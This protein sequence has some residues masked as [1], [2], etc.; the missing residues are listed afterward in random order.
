MT[1]KSSTRVTAALLVLAFFLGADY[2]AWAWATTR[3]DRGLG[4]LQ[5]RIAA[6]GWRFDDPHRTSA[7]WPFAARLVLRNA[8]L[9]SADGTVSWSAGRVGI[10][11]SIFRP[12]VITIV[13]DG[14]QTL[15]LPGL[16]PAVIDAQILGLSVSS[17]HPD[18]ATAIARS[19]AVHTALG[20]IDVDRAGLTLTWGA[21]Q[22]HLTLDL[23]GAQLP[24]GAGWPLGRAIGSLTLGL[25]ASPAWP[26]GS[27]SASAASW[28]DAGGRIA[29]DRAALDWGALNAT[30]K[31]TAR[32]D[33]NLQPAVHL[34]V[35]IAGAESAVAAL[36][37]SG[38]LSPGTALAAGAIL[39][40]IAAPQ[41]GSDGALSLPL[42]LKA[43][44][45][46]LA[47]IPIGTVPAIAWPR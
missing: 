20:T 43:G 38:V 21:G 23:A 31:G 32:L 25:T 18:A 26:G 45:L 27:Q 7:G 41:P 17:S 12:G 10:G 42:S 29:I 14:S 5:A 36:A 33:P 47:H 2:A 11:V 40:V 39:A 35:R 3:L 19:L 9:A 28:R 44:K 24:A 6:E 34:D 30:A 46:T 1:R 8:S 15:R 13:A 22:A 16:A 4:R 37:R